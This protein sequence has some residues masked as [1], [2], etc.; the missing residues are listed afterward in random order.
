LKITKKKAEEDKIALVVKLGEILDKLNDI[1][2]E[3]EHLT[4]RLVNT[5][6]C[7]TQ[8]KKKCAQMTECNELLADEVYKMKKKVGGDVVGKVK[9]ILV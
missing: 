1:E 8:T 9:S 2:T 3:N 6:E 7:L 4:E 5:E